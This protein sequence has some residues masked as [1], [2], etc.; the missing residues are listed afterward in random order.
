MPAPLV[1]RMRC[2]ASLQVTIFSCPSSVITPLDM[3]SSMASL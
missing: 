3:D 1:R 2:P